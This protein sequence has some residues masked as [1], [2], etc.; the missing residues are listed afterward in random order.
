MVIR[1][2]CSWSAGAVILLPFV[3]PDLRRHAGAVRANLRTYLALGFFQMTAGALLFLAL[4]FTTAINASLVNG[5]QPAV[6]VL[7]AWLLLREKIAPL[8]M[9][10]VVVAL[11]GVI[12]MVIR[13][14][15]SR[16]VAM[17]FNIGDL[18]VVASICFYAL[19]AVNLP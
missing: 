17:E 13:G 14:D 18:I 4:N 1:R 6:T 3:W 19:Y 9:L 7:I 2:S 8:H 12:V 10:G 5:T 11:V 16:L 15:V